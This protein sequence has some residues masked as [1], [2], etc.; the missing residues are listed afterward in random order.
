MVND[1]VAI[2][3]SW[4]LE[5]KAIVMTLDIN[6][7]MAEVGKFIFEDRDRQNALDEQWEHTQL[8]VIKNEAMVVSN[9]NIH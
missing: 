7:D 6:N 2:V 8:R 5:A 9:S 4:P 1:H 3:P